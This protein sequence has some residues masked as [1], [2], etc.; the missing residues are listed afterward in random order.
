M[1]PVSVVIPAYNAASVLPRAI[2]SVLGQTS[3]PEEV[4]VVDDGSTDNTAQV[5][6]QYGPSITYIRQDNAGA[7][8]ARNRGIAEATGEWIAFL[9]SDDEWLPPK[10]Q[11]QW[12]V[13]QGDAQLI[14]CWCNTEA[15]VKDVARIPPIP[16]LLKAE[17]AR[18]EPL[19]FFVAALRGV[20]FQTSGFL[21]HRSVFEK[22]GM[23]D[24]LLRVAEDRDMW[25]RIAMKYPRVGYCPCVCYRW[26]VDTP[27]S[28]TKGTADRSQSLQALF[29]NMRRARLF[30]P[31][32][33]EVFQAYGR[34][35]AV[36]Y[37]IRTASR[38]ITMSFR[39]TED[40]KA[41]FRVTEPER[42]LLGVLRL[43]PAPLARS[44]GRVM[45]KRGGWTP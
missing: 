23:F 26:Y 24:P 7:S 33:S 44:F 42:L 2:E 30:G 37:L 1:I 38:E 22:V 15:V 40:A 14:W 13:L 9:D 28:L 21:I 6:T 34:P 12:E 17:V 41:L 11:Y 31:D 35:L 10:L 16:S 18:G 36:D 3:R 4:I 27:R 45:S 43:L 20:P 25:W 19:P 39:A 29:D 8:A 32:V 5:A